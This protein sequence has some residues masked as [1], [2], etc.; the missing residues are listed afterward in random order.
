MI[1]E[2]GNAV[3]GQDIGLILHSYGTL[4]VR[5][6]AAAEALKNARAAKL[7]QNYGTNEQKEYKGEGRK[8]LSRC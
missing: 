3:S 7:P 5:Q 1:A 6:N 8:F 2:A 4:C